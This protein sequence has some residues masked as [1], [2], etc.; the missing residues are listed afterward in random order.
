MALGP[1]VFSPAELLGW[2]S[3]PP[4]ERLCPGK[5]L[6]RFTGPHD[7]WYEPIPE[8]WLPVDWIY[9]PAR[10]PNYATELIASR[11]EELDE[12]SELFRLR[13]YG[14]PD[15]RAWGAWLGSLG[16]DRPLRRG[17]PALEVIADRMYDT[18]RY[19]YLVPAWRRQ[20]TAWITYLDNIEDQIST[21]L[22]LIELLGKKVAPIPPGALSL[23]DDVRKYLDAAEKAL[24]LTPGGRAGK[25]EWRKRQ[26]ETARQKREARG[27]IAMLM[28]WVRQ[29]YTK[30]IEAAQATGTWFD[31]GIILGPIMG[32]I[33][34]GLWG[35]GA[36]TLDNYLVAVDAL[37]PGYREDF[38][39]NA[40][41][42]EQR[43]DLALVDLVESVMTTNLFGYSLEGFTRDE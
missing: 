37:A 25:V 4:R 24:A 39:R 20:M 2:N 36:K 27:R 23:A 30:L 17:W 16:C 9:D 38:Y 14:D 26:Q 3:A 11:L 31:V 18:A 10:W 41:E 19:K 22:W 6:P 5:T 35:L 12:F 34:E 33:D 7:N 43:V 40:T 29:N 1:Q 32:W 28:L 42:L 13:G 15:K 8:F 21:I